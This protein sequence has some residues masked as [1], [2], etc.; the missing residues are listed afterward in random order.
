M[1]EAGGI[2]GAFLLLITALVVWS[3]AGASFAHDLGKL[4]NNQPTEPDKFTLIGADGLAALMADRNAHVN[5]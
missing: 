2:R 1:R 5:I 3:P 4:L